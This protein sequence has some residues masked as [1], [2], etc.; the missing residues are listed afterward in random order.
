M[1]L[2][3]I[4]RRIEWKAAI[5]A[6]A[7]RLIENFNDRAYFEA[8][9]R[10]RGPV[11]MARPKR[12]IGPPSSSRSRGGKGSRSALLA[13]ICGGNMISRGGSARL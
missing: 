11:S 4:R 2:G 12:A 7:R 3:L 9:E 5:A 13:P 8:R 10:V 6:D 1:V